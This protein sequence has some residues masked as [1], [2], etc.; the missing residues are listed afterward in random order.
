MS[1]TLGKPIMSE[2]FPLQFNY[3]AEQSFTSFYTTCNREAV[4]HLTD[5]ANNRGEHQL[6]LWGEKGTGKSH[7]LHACCQEAHQNKLTAFYLNL[8]VND[9]PDTSIL[10]GLD[11]FDIICIDNLQHCCGHK[12]WEMALFNFYNRYRDNNKHLVLSANVRPNDLKLQLPDL[13]TRFNWGL[14]LKLQEL[15]DDDMIAAFTCKAKYL[16]LE[17]SPKVG[18]FIQKNYTHNLPALWDL[19]PKLEQATL[20]AK[21]KLSVPFVKQILAEQQPA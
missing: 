12:A 18:E 3:N 4:K 1:D 16:G 11:N 6:F 17:I 20:V 13:I 15:S 2:Q 21:R 5:I 14:T 7:L 10:E 8:P 19:L 9:L